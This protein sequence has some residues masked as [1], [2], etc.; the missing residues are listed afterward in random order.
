MGDTTAGDGV[1]NVCC[2]L[3]R[4]G[5]ALFLHISVGLRPRT[6]QDELRTPA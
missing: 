3:F 1:T 5:E 6:R 2:V 4:K